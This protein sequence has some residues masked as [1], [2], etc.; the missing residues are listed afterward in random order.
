MI[1]PRKGKTE[2]RKIIIFQGKP[3]EKIQ[4]G[5]LPLLQ[6]G[7]APSKAKI[8]QLDI[9]SILVCCYRLSVQIVYHEGVEIDRI[10]KVVA[11]AEFLS[12]HSIE[13]STT[14]DNRLQFVR[15]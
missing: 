9:L 8:A 12:S 2:K 14:G 15:Y 1:I 13:I 3:G 4:F 11:F 10:F 7:F 6:R 5:L